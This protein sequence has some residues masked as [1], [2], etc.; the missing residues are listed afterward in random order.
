MSDIETDGGSAHDNEDQI[1]HLQEDSGSEYQ[2]E[3]N[4]QSDDAANSV[5]SERSGTSNRSRNSASPRKSKPKENH[6]PSITKSTKATYSDAYRDFYN[7][8]LEELIHPVH[9]ITHA[10]S[11]S[12]I[13]VAVWTPLEKE[14]LFRKVSA[15]GK[16]DIKG[17]SSAIRTKSETEVRQYLSLLDQGT[18][19]GNV[20][21]ALPVFSAADVSP[22]FEVS[23]QSE[24]LLEEYANGLAQYQK[25]SDQ[26]R[27]KKR[28]GD[29][30]LLTE[31]VAQEVE[32]QVMA[33]DGSYKKSGLHDEVENEDDDL[34]SAGSDQETANTDVESGQEDPR[35]DTE[36]E[37]DPSG[38][39]TARNKELNQQCP[40]PLEDLMVPAAD[41]LDLPMWLRLSRLFMYQS[42]ELGDS[43]DKLITSRHETPSM[44]HTAFQDFHNL[45]VSLTRRVVQATIFQT[46]TRLRAR[47]KD[48]P[49]ARVTTTDVR[50]ATEILDLQPNPRKFW[51]SVPRKHG[52]RV[53]ERGSKFARGQSR[54]GIELSLE[55]AEERL[56][57][58]NASVATET[59]DDVV[60]TVED[61]TEEDVLDPDQYYNDPEL[62]TEASDTEDETPIDVPD[63]QHSDAS[64]DDEAAY[65]PTDDEEAQEAAKK[66][67]HRK[68][69]MERNFQRA[70]D[71]YLEAVDQEISRVHEVGMWD[72]LGAA[73]PND[74]KNEEVEIPRQPVIKRRLSDTANWRDG[75]EY[76]SP[77]E[78]GFDTVQPEAFSSMHKR[79]EHSRKRRRMAYEHLER[80][81]L[82]ILPQQAPET[83]VVK[84]ST[85][86]TQ[87]DTEMQD[88]PSEETPHVTTETFDD[89]VPRKK[90]PAPV[91]K[92]L[93]RASSILSSSKA[94][95]RA[96]S[97]REGSHDSF[98]S[99]RSAPTNLTLL[100]KL[101]KRTPAQQIE[102]DLRRAEEERKAEETRRQAEEQVREEKRKARAARK[103]L[104]EEEKLALKRE[105]QE[106]KARKAQENR[107]NEERKR[108]AA[109]EKQRAKEEKRKVR[110]EEEGAREL[111]RTAKT[112]KRNAEQAEAAREET[113]VE[114]EEDTTRSTKPRSKKAKRKSGF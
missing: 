69:R 74:I 72:T 32:E 47:D 103:A 46:M 109:E 59:D 58:G 13:G 48:Q 51:A 6:K 5:R 89:G 45:T 30:W 75:F 68:G 105:A 94:L 29:Y 113:N 80:E 26:K 57:A 106:K 40:E 63:D 87:V 3:D 17:I 25:R 35:T 112:E 1:N 31:E 55:E 37:P 77:W 8:E 76:H 56:G 34:E 41:L 33:R 104:S 78:L 84:K 71:A 93:S 4:D 114:H 97:V 27:E 38:E 24:E 90:R 81:G 21:K 107:R 22:A 73:P 102:E 99:A 95:S 12:E 49:G 53:Y 42:S 92:A 43:W 7:A 54:A 86:P 9:A 61:D 110:E 83:T 52:L 82:I 2:G 16:D 111:R 79:G 65:H 19:E 67:R 85:K 100:N 39:A 96:S 50:A 14:V 98:V 23:K 20:T 91:H 10:L 70:H 28:H 44:Y 66:K 88:A 62:W 11:A 108:L 101:T 15:L 64:D 60:Q 18:V 36:D